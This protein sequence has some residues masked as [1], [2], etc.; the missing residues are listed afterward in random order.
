VDENINGS[1]FGMNYVTVRKDKLT[2]DGSKRLSLQSKKYRVAEKRGNV[3][4]L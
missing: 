4:I 2:A 1:L 3:Q